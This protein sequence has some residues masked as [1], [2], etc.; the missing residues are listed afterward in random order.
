MAGP[1]QLG[2]GAA[3]AQTAPSSPAS[4][5]SSFPPVDPKGPSGKA[6]PEVEVPNPDVAAVG[7]P[8]VPPATKPG[9]ELLDRRTVKS[10]TFAT[11]KPGELRTEFYD[12]PVNFKD[13]QGRWF[14]IDDTLGAS[15]DGRRGNAAN[16]FDLSVADSSTDKAVARLAIDDKHSVGFALDGAAKVKGK[17]DQRSVTYPKVHKDTDMRLTSR[18][19][20][21]K[22]DLV[23]ASGAAPDRFVFPLEL[24]GLTASLNETGDVVYRDEAGV[25]RARTPHGFMTDANID[26]RS[27]EAPMSLGVAYALIPSDK[28]TALEVRLDR[29]WLDDPAR[30]WPVTVDPQ[31]VA[32]AGNDDTY[33]MSGFH[34]D[35]SYDAELKVGTYDGGSHVGRSYIHFDTAALAGAG[36]SSAD[37]KVAERWSWN[38]AAAWPGL[39]RVTQGWDGRTMMDFPGAAFD[40]NPM[41]VA[42]V[43]GSCPN[44]TVHY[45]V[46]AAAGYW[47]ANGPSSGLGVMLGTNEGDNNAWKKFASTE[48]GLPAMLEVWYTPPNRPPYLAS[49]VTPAN[50]SVFGTATTS[51]SA[52]YSDPDGG[53]GY[54]AF[55]VWNYQNQL[56]WSQWSGALCSGCR[57]TLNVPAQPDNWYQVMVIGHDGA[58]YSGGNA[59]P[60]WSSP[61]WYFLDTLPPAASELTPVN[62]AS[63]PSP[64][65]V[66]ARYSEPYGFTG[67]MYFW[68]YTTGGTRIV[69][70]WSA[71]TNSGAVAGLAIPNLAPGTYNLWAMPWDTRQ[72][73]PQIGPNTFTVGSPT[74]TTTAAPTTTT[75]VAP[76]TTTVPSTT[77]TTVPATTTTVGP[78]TTTTVPGPAPEVPTAL[79]PAMNTTIAAPITA[80][81]R[82]SEPNNSSGTVLFS[83]YNSATGA[84]AAEE[85]STAVCSGCTA[86]AQLAT[87]GDGVYTLYATASSG[88][89]SSGRS[90]PNTLYVPKVTSTITVAESGFSES[91]TASGSSFQPSTS[92]DIYFTNPDGSHDFLRSV[93]TDTSG[94]FNNATINLSTVGAPTS[95]GSSTGYIHVYVANTG[96]APQYCVATASVST[97]SETADETLDES[98]TSPGTVTVTGAELETKRR[99][100]ESTTRPNY[101]KAKAQNSPEGYSEADLVRMRAGRAPVGADGFPMELH[102]I[103]PLSRGG[104]NETSNLQEMTRTD[105][106]LGGNYRVNHS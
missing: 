105:H 53:S 48:A 15:K 89:R 56:V 61:Q 45:N 40:P 37:L 33:V 35:N 28:G 41:P 62:G 17:A 60:T 74:T 13:P 3:A 25:E 26:P 23:L 68:L 102:H 100:F 69:E 20:G 39:Y 82:Y 84:L 90:G 44:R 72:T 87:V 47:A 83:L 81:A 2:T 32:W 30:A 8:S 7:K 77:T 80:S 5:P 86:S 18:P 66:S 6:P 85:R 65:Q 49:G 4:T 54:L 57:A 94:I 64:T 21:V 50:G 106:R 99:E 70:N 71:I 67:Y 27:G 43:E 97:F 79:M 76:N 34:R 19:T 63:G 75:T 93:V 1:L 52:V 38:C 11:D 24:K 103:Q 73:G 101:W 42:S 51:V 22:E 29:A 36:I 31:L 9:E 88:N 92:Y 96:T 78:T 14:A 104:S 95:G 59:A 55:G 12:A 46:A 91:G 58:Q 10:K 16:V 98:L